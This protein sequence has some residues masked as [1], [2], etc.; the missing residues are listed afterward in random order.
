MDSATSDVLDLPVTGMHCTACAGTVARALESVPGVAGA[1]VDV[2]TETAHLSLG[3]AR[4][5]GASLA[6]ALAAS[7][8]GIAAR[9]VELAIPGLSSAG[10]AQTAEAV[11]RADPGVVEVAVNPAS[12]TAQLAIVP[13]LTDAARL[14]ARLAASGFAATEGAR[15]DA[16]RREARLADLRALAGLALLLP[17]LVEMPLHWLGFHGFLPPLVQA[18]LAT[19]VAAIALPKMLRGALAALR[20]RTGTMDQLVSLGTLAA[21]GLSYWHLL[22]GGPLYFEAAAVPAFVLAGKRL[23]ARAKRKASDAITALASLRPDTATRLSD[24]GTPAEIPAAALR[25]GER[26]LVGA[27]KSFPA[28]GIVLEGESA[29]DESLVTGESLPVPKRPGD[30]VIA[31]AINADGALVVRVTQAGEGTAVAR[32]LKLVREAQASRAP[33]QAL[34][35]RVSAVFVPTVILLATLTFVFWMGWGAGHEVALVNAIA[36]LVIACP[37]ALGLATPAAIVAGLGA[38][39]RRGVLFASAAATEK[40]RALDVIVLDKTGTLTTGRPAVAAV[41]GAEDTLLLAAALSAGATH[42]L[43]RGVTA[44]AA[45]RGLAVP[46]ARLVMNFPGRGVQGRVGM[47]RLKFGNAAFAG[48]APDLAAEAVRHDAQGASIAWLA[49]EGVGVIGFV[50]LADPIRPEA[51]AALAALGDLGIGAVLASGDAPGAVA[52]VA[53]SLGI[54]E[55]HARMS[56]A[57]KAALVRELQGQGRRVAMLGDGVNDAPG[58]AAADLS[59]AM[60]GGADAAI[61]TADIALLRDD[62]RLAAS[63]IRIAR[64]TG[65]KVRQNLALAFGY[66]IL[67]IPLAMAGML[68][69]AV[70]GAAMAA[71]SISVVANALRLRAAR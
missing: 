16:S 7:G 65:A 68:S 47:R 28:D 53:A 27:G 10:A 35:D 30:P 56:P 15:R 64:A 37:C 36:V 62:P 18:V 66:N 14:V 20:A 42:P 69:P 5:D 11:L 51:P 25:A 61:A 3:P 6:R 1:Q 19:A 9:P 26:V 50:A 43:A 31:G 39:A 23:E 41:A 24:D 45:A 46:A 70:A 55:H 8:Y 67:A 40:A 49:E 71:S 2:A 52:K 34:A 12:E 48:E 33:M 32:I 22:A 17:F 4:P 54:A 38:A 21:L 63:A 44:E 58:F 29:A 57:G 59:L 60:G 13:G